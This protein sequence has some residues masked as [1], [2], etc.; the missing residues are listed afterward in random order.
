[1][2]LTHP[3]NRARQMAGDRTATIFGPRI[4]TWAQFSQQV[5]HLAGAL[6]T[7]GVEAGDR[8]AVLALNSDRYIESLYGIWWCGGVVVPLNYRFSIAEIAEVL[9]DSAARVLIVDE[10]FR[11]MVDAL[12][13]N[14]RTVDHVVDAGDGSVCEG[15]LGYDDLIARATPMPE[16]NRDGEDTAG[17]FYTSGTTGKPR[18]VMLTHRNLDT[19]F[20]NSVAQGFIDEH[21]VYLHVA[22]MFHMADCAFLGAVTMV[23]ATHVVVSR[24]DVTEIL[25]AISVHRVT[26]VLLVPTMLR[27]LLDA[28]D[29]ADH[30]PDLSSLRLIIYGASPM[31]SS[32]ME[33]AIKALPSVQ[34]IQ[35]YGMT[36]LSP[37]ASVLEPRYH[38]LQGP[39]SLKL[40]SAGRA[41]LTAEIKIADSEDV[42]VPRGTIGEILV[43][44]DGVMKGYWKEPELTRHSL[45]GGWMHT[46]DL[47]YMDEQGFLFVVDRLKDMIIS[48]AENIYPFEVEEAL[49]RL[50]TVAMCA[51]IGI[52][53]EVWGERV[54]AVVVPEAGCQLTENQII[55]HC[56]SQIAHYKCPRSVEI[57]TEKLPVNA[58]G[59][60]LK[61][62]LRSAH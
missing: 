53:D 28:L 58:A 11:S 15:T 48:G 29:A 26:N 43:R 2:Q 35:A 24:F 47:G 62:Q 57:R 10:T 20:L 39:L 51:V 37:V 19:S 3:L 22:P 12:Q 61:K 5:A 45:R 38:T 13:T 9:N 56:R 30:V 41:A 60:I 16:V 59:K 18:G 25:T 40:R 4:Q 8:V 21:S 23:A 34:F 33:R 27:L 46:G 31:P 32:L 36:E 50:P 55:E 44:G 42:E 7:L 17:I 14:S 6:R 49:Y 52:A 54:H 1:M